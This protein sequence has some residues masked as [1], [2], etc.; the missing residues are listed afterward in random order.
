LN[1]K[2]SLERAIAVQDYLIAHGIDKSR[3]R[4]KGCGET[5]P[6]AINYNKDGTP[7]KQGMALNRRFEF[8]VLSVDGKYQDV[9]APILVPDNLK[10]KPKH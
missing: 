2:L 8:K 9:V 1:M 5:Q 6:I 7:N 3:L 10:D 4:T